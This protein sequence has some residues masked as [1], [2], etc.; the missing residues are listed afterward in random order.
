[1]AFIVKRYNFAKDVFN[2][3]ALLRLAL[4]IFRLPLGDG[5]IRIILVF[6]EFKLNFLPG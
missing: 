2:V 3:T 6:A 5:W 1:M 4:I